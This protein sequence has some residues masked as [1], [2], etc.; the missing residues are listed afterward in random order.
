LVYLSIIWNGVG[1]DSIVGIAIGY[2]CAVWGSNTVGARLSA[3]V[4]TGSGAH[5]AS[6]TIST[7]SFP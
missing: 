1:Q 7:G 5:P 3:P 6:Y 2:G 4:H